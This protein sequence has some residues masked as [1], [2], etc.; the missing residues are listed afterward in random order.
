MKVSKNSFRPPP[1]VDSSVVRLEPLNPPPPINFVEWDGM[2]RLCFNRKNKTLA[3]IFRHKPVLKLLDENMRTHR[4]LHGGGGGCARGAS[5]R[6][7][8]ALGAHGREVRLQYGM[9]KG[10]RL[11]CLE[12][13]SWSCAWRLIHH[14]QERGGGLAHR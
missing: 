4:A 6:G 1:K 12:H 9:Q 5:Q 7:S 13:A 10:A 3:A 14:H 2:V 8:A 11:V